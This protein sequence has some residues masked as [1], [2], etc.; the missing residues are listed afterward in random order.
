MITGA[1][2]PF[3]EN[4]LALVEQVFKEKKCVQVNG[5]QCTQ[6]KRPC[7]HSEMLRRHKTAPLTRKEPVN[8]TGARMAKLRSQNWKAGF[9]LR[10]PGFGK[11][12]GKGLRSF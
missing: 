7:V 12:V 11:G 10:A 6:R 2:P 3:D 8:G 4:M 5:T 9:L 1:Q